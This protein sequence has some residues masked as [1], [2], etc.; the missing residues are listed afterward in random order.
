MLKI[1]Y[2]DYDGDNDDDDD[3]DQGVEDDDFC[4]S[5]CDGDNYNDVVVDMMIAAETIFWGDRERSQRLIEGD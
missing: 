4:S 3:D 1:S 5:D 2:W